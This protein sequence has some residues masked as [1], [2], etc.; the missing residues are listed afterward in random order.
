MSKRIARMLEVITSPAT[1]EIFC[2]NRHWVFGIP[3]SRQSLEPEHR[4]EQ[5][6]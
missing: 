5:G 6:H 3:T 4:P 2:H 1:G